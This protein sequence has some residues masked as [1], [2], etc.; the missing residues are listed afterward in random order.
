MSLMGTSTVRLEGTY[1]GEP[2]TERIYKTH[3]MM[4]QNG[5][6]VTTEPKVGV[7]LAQ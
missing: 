4:K 6:V 3:I 5:V 1:K 2:L 7:Y